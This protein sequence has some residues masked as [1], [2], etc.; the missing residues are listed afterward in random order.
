MS[1]ESHENIPRPFPNRD[2]CLIKILCHLYDVYLVEMSHGINKFLVF[3]HLENTIL[4]KSLLD[5]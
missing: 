2:K 5:L 1:N 3:I 4:I